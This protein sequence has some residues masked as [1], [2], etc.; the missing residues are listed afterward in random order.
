MVMI[1]KEKT[2]ENEG[3]EEYDEDP[4][5]TLDD[6]EY[7]EADPDNEYYEESINWGQ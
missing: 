7:E 2:D 4:D 3:D 5:W 1:E 6:E